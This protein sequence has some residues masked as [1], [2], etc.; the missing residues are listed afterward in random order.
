MM[1]MKFKLLYLDLV[2]LELEMC[3]G[4]KFRKKM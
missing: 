3:G 2:V 1:K 4:A